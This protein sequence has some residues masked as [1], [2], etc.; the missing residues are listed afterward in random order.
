MLRI[1]NFNFILVKEK[2]ICK[3]YREGDSII[4]KEMWFRE[5]KGKINKRK[6]NSFVDLFIMV[7]CYIVY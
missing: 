4:K 7:L 2:F 1:K 3:D 6:L 5:E